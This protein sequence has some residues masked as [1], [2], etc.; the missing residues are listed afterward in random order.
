MNQS[1]NQRLFR[2]PIRK[3]IH[4]ARFHWLKKVSQRYMPNYINVFELGCHDAKSIIFLPY[5][6]IEYLGLDADWEGGLKKAKY[7][8]EEIKEYKFLKVQK[9]DEFPSINKKFDLVICLETLEHLPENELKDYIFK[10]SSLMSNYLFITVPNEIGFV[11]IV[12]LFLKRFFNMHPDK[13]TFMEMI[14]Q[15]FGRV[16]KVKRYN[17]KGFSWL[18]LLKILKNEFQIVSLE[19]IP[20]SFL[21]KSFNFG[22][23]IVLKKKT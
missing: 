8:Y 20:F 9:I 13:Y 19:G 21:P 4:M 14:N 11:F 7:I 10:L 17:H 22:V 6:P 18:E 5:P 15:F 12:K 3:R 1:Y 2:N 16:K 23:G